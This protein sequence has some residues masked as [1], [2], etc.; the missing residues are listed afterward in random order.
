M[1]TVCRA[2]ALVSIL[3]VMSAAQQ[4]AAK[5]SKAPSKAAASTPAATTEARHQ[6]ALS[7]VHML[8]PKQHTDQML[9]Q[10][11]QQFMYAAAAD[12][13]RRGI[14]I[15]PDFESKM[16]AALSGLVTYGEVTNWASNFYAEH[17][18]LSELHQM[19]A[20][21]NG[22]VGRKLIAAQPEIGQQTM[23]QLLVAVDH[24]L[25]GAM[26]KQGLT[27][28]Q[29]RNAQIPQPAPVPQAT[30]PPQGAQPAPQAPEATPP[31]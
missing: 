26:E 28:P 27:P 23:R 21:Y 14:T 25:P 9:G 11:G 1:R 19:E 18:T 20:F 3:A 30:P 31:K 6:A 8:M 2:L 10:I 12:Y 29:P 7:L 17:F 24:R 4:P 13:K 22:P 16:K 15:P 5:T